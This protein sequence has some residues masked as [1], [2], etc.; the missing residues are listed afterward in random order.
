MAALFLIT[1]VALLIT[2][3][4]L[5]DYLSLRSCLDH[6]TDWFVRYNAYIFSKLCHSYFSSECIDYG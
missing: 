6:C 4:A 3:E 5:Q 1:Q 2:P